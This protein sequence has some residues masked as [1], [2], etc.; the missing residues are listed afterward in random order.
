MSL[1]LPGNTA[2]V[3]SS[4]PVALVITIMN[5]MKTFSYIRE[6]EKSWKGS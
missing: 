6:S 3:V 1:H 4:Q 2:I 5:G